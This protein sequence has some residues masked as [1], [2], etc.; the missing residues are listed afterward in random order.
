MSDPTDGL[1]ARV[2]GLYDRPF[3]D[4][5][6]R[7][8]RL[9]LQT[10]LAC[11]TVRYPPGPVCHACLSPEAEWRPVSGSGEILSW[12]VFH[13]GYLPGY[14]PPYNVIAVR[15]D[16]GPILMSNLEG[17]PP[18]GSWIGQRVEAVVVRPEGGY[19]LPRFVCAD[20]A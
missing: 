18:A 12:V 20:R 6:E 2:M 14:T 7:T 17:P 19:A 3:W 1:P 8:E 13:K 10:C 16:E 5:L 15:L 4:H 9:A 11:G